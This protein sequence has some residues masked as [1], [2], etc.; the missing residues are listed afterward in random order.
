[1]NAADVYAGSDGELTK[2]Y[3]SELETKGPIGLVAMN[4]FRA[5]KCSARAKVYRG[6]VRGRGSYKSMAYERK[7]WS[8]TCK[9][10]FSDPASTHLAE[11][12]RSRKLAETAA[13]E[14]RNCSSGLLFY[15]EPVM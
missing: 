2:R 12:F 1:M 5:Q 9:T 10:R 14:C 3:Y 7:S 15:V 6:G 13:D 8:A 4:L 11:R